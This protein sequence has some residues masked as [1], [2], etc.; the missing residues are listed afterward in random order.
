MCGRWSS[1]G[2]I[3]IVLM[4][5]SVEAIKHLTEILAVTGVGA[6]MIGEGDL[7]QQLGYPATIA[8][9]SWSKPNTTS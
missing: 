5:E 3:M 8:I 1:K 7:S 2:E 6:I 4:I 9:P